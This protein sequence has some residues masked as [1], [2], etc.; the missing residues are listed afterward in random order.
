MSNWRVLSQN[1][2]EEPHPELDLDF[3]LSQPPI[4][5]L[6]PP[7][8]A[9]LHESPQE[10]A[11]PSQPSAQSRV[12]QGWYGNFQH[13]ARALVILVQVGCVDPDTRGVTFGEILKV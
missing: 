3:S 13:D 6:L 1:Q 2:D 4:R 11:G 8:P 9:P 12:E 7:S 10:E 5:T